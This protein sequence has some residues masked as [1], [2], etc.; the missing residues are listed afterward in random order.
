M[1]R[2]AHGNGPAG[3]G[4]PQGKQRIDEALALTGMEPLRHHSLLTLSSGERQRAFLAQVL[5]QDPALLLLDEPASHLDLSYARQLYQLVDQW[6]IQTGRAV[7]SVVHDLSVARR[8]GT[9]AL[10][11]KDGRTQGFGPCREVLTDEALSDAWQMDV[12]GWMR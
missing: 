4:D 3:R 6:R 11:L 7:I 10:L 1:G 9:H 5:C 2:Y 12:F 8:F